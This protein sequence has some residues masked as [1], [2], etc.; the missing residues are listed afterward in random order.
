MV[1]FGNHDGTKQKNIAFY[2]QTA[3]FN[4]TEHRCCLFLGIKRSSSVDASD[5]GNKMLVCFVLRLIVNLWLNHWCGVLLGLPQQLP[6]WRKDH[7]YCYR[8]TGSKSEKIKIGSIWDVFRQDLGHYQSYSNILCIHLMMPFISVSW[9][10]ISRVLR[11][12]KWSSLILTKL[13]CLIVTFWFHV[14]I[15]Y[16]SIWLRY[17]N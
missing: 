16:L 14:M 9:R 12:W 11:L 6:S 1:E 17:M 13:E 5:R 4:I 7:C 2:L 15:F 10:N 3:F 8:V